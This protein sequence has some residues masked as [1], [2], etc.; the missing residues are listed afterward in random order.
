MLY[1]IVNK[2]KS[3]TFSY[4]LLDFKDKK[5]LM[6]EDKSFKNHYEEFEIL[7]NWIK[8]GEKYVT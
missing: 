6:D 2:V 8:E 7:L 5:E 4:F 1:I 3:F